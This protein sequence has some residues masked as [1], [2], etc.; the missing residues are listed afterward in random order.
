MKKLDA[1]GVKISIDD[2]GTGYSSLSYLK[3]FPIK[4]LKIDRSFVMDIPEDPEDMAITRAIIS[5]GHSL[6]L[7]IVAEGLKI[8]LSWNFS[9]ALT[10]ITDRDTYSTNLLVLKNSPK[11]YWHQACKSV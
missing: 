4:T 6:D 1:L 10:A 11:L 7:E 9:I 3:K 8:G 5:M 2:F